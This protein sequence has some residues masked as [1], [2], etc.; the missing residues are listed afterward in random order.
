MSLLHSTVLEDKVLL[1]LVLI[2]TALL[3]ALLLI[4]INK[5]TPAVRSYIFSSFI[6]ATLIFLFLQDQLHGF[7]EPSIET[8]QAVKQHYS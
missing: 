8:F 5:T 2:D 1:A 6:I 4:G 3:I 7:S